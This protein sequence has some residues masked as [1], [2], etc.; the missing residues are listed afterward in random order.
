MVPP[1][2]GF[3]LQSRRSSTRLPSGLDCFSG[4]RGSVESAA[5]H[6]QNRWT[7]LYVLCQALAVAS[8]PPEH[9]ESLPLSLSFVNWLGRSVLDPSTSAAHVLHLGYLLACVWASLRLGSSVW[10]APTRMLWQQSVHALVGISVWTKT[11]QRGMPWG[12]FAQSFVGCLFAVLRVYGKPS[13]TPWH[14][15]RTG[16]W[17]SFRP[18]RTL[19]VLPAVLAGSEDRPVIA[20]CGVASV[21][22]SSG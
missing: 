2:C 20:G 17:I 1:L 4:K 5:L 9:S 12:L 13:P 6:V 14:C 18:C 10:V 7:L 21:S 15:S 8:A 3:R 11:T 19:D 16:L 22:G